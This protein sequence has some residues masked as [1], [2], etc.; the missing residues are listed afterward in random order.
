MGLINEGTTCYMNS[1]LQTFFTIGSLRRAIYNIPSRRSSFDKKLD[2]S[3]EEAKI[4]ISLQR[5]FYNL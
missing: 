1:L 5:I 2:S 4:P 3:G